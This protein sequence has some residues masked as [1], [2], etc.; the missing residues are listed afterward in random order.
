ML[1]HSEEKIDTQHPYVSAG[2]ISLPT[3]TRNI[4]VNYGEGEVV[5]LFTLSIANNKIHVDVRKKV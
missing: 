1:E 2:G 4:K 3:H 5:H